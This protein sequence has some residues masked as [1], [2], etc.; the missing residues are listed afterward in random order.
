MGTKWKEGHRMGELVR[1]QEPK[2][3]WRGPEEANIQGPVKEEGEQDKSLRR[4]QSE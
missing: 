3:V 4:P 2:R 1:K